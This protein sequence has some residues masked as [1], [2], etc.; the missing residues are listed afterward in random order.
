VNRARDLTVAFLRAHPGEAA[1][2]LEQLTAAETS[3]LL[4]AIPG[5]VAA[6]VIARLPPG[7]AARSLASLADEPVVR[8]LRRLNVPATAAL[9]RHLP[10][11]RRVRLL[12]ELPVATAVG[13][14]ML[15][16]YPEDS[17]G[18]LADTEVL[19]AR[20]N[21]SVREVLARL[22][23]AT[24]DAGDFLYIVDEER[25][26][27]T[28]MRPASLLL[29]PTSMS[30]GGAE[31]ETVP[32]LPAQAAPRSVRDH[33]GW[34]QYSTLPVVE[35]NGRLVGAL[36]HGVL[37]Q[38]LEHSPPRQ[39]NDEASVLAVM[40]STAWMLMAALLQSVVNELPGARRRG[41]P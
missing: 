41:N 37:I 8:L 40:G 4:T 5:R 36:R 26:L 29:A 17:I 32:A 7:F 34:R 9:L 16:R 2:V 25:R 12:E 38:V 22:K 10:E 24:R 15:L 6:P 35:R 28:C 19:T 1:R 18:A 21:E 20:P 39:E 11:P 14:R 3:S 23:A 30:I 13:C 27:R 31:A 33:S